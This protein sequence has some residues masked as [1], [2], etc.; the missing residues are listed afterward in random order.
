MIA[1]ILKRKVSRMQFEAPDPSQLSVPAPSLGSISEDGAA[2]AAASSPPKNGQAGPSLPL[3][4][5]YQRPDLLGE[6]T[7]AEFQAFQHHHN[8]PVV[9]PKV[10]KVKF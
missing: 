6:Y 7:R 3:Q 2:A 1:K 5:E 9:V 10:S 8:R 4:Y